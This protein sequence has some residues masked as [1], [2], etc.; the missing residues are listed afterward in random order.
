MKKYIYLIGIIAILTSCSS[1]YY[2]VYLTK[3]DNLEK[4]DNNLI[5]QDDNCMVYYN[6]CSDKG[7]IGFTIFNKTNENIT[8]NLNKSF[9][10]LNGNTN[11]YFKNRTYVEKHSFGTK[12]NHVKSVITNTITGQ[13]TR[14]KEK[15]FIVIPP[16]ANKSINEYT[17]NSQRIINCSLLNSPK[18]K[19]IDHICYE[20]EYSPL[21]F[22]NII[23][24]T[25]NSGEEKT[26][27]NNFYVYEMYNIPC[28]EIEIRKKKELCG[29]QSQMYNTFI[30][31]VSP[32]TFY[33]K[34][35]PKIDGFKH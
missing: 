20:K 24:Y 1:A 27:R 28:S 12:R 29:E 5:Y 19:K 35:Y 10:V 22:S 32:N 6:L 8:V 2:Q 26:I 14:I 30:K 17:I 18:R 34:Y 13:E 23:S 21:V 15:K 9:F 16:N 31:I 7:N 3:Y 11:D 4:K 33:L 25:T